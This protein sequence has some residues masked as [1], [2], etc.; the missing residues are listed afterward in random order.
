MLA[1][2]EN[3]FFALIPKVGSAIRAM[4]RY[5]FRISDMSSE[6]ALVQRPCIEMAT[7]R[8]VAMF[9]TKP[10]VREVSL[11]RDY[12]FMYDNF[13]I[14][15]QSST[16]LVL[17]RIDDLIHVLKFDTRALKYGSPNDEARSGHPLSK[18][19]PLL[20]GLYEVENSPWISEQVKANRVHDRHQ[21]SMFDGLKHH[22]VCFKDVMFEVTGLSF[23][24]L[25]LT[26]DE[27][28]DLVSQELASMD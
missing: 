20:Y 5:D 19:G 16:Y 24:E 18:Y 7:A 13:V 12:H 22:I 8:E 17:E 15:T 28:R 1:G 9:T 27:L 3:A 4:V 21:D 6:Y 2:L 11:Q 10:V 26:E 14:A 23:E 25:Q